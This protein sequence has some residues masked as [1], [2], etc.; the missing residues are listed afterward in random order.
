MES[1]KRLW[2]HKLLK[3]SKNLLIL[4]LTKHSKQQTEMYRF[5]IL[6]MGF[7]RTV[8]KLL[9]Q[10]YNLKKASWIAHPI[11][12]QPLQNQSIT[13]PSQLT[14]C[15]NH[16]PS[17]LT[18]IILI[19]AKSPNFQFLIRPFNQFMSFLLLSI[20]RKIS[21]RLIPTHPQSNS[22]VKITALHL[23]QFQETSIK[24]CIINRSMGIRLREISISNNS[25]NGHFS[26]IRKWSI[27]S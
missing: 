7:C 6:L 26:L 10:V 16:K 4:S 17:L 19:L 21:Y 5:L 22:L 15:K 3:L 25:M 14:E 18:E 1:C 9:Y 11:L 2:N 20:N 13:N 24:C 23:L 8:P 12:S 27:R